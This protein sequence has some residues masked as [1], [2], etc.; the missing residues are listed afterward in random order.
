MIIKK[1]KETVLYV[2]DVIVVKPKFPSLSNFL[3]ESFE[4]IIENIFILASFIFLALRNLQNISI[5]LF[6]VR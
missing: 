6:N 5:F 2:I 3:E 4:R 1:K